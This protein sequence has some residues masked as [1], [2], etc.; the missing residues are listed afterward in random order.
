MV[1]FL[2]LF[3]ILTQ[4]QMAA[5][6]IGSAHVRP[7]TQMTFTLVTFISFPFGLICHLLS[8]AHLSMGGFFSRN[9]KMFLC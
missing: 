6:E 1:R 3:R 2:F 7:E 4:R 8:V 9:I 5:I